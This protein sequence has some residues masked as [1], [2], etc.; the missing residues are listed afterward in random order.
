MALKDS[1]KH[2][3]DFD[4]YSG[5]LSKADMDNNLDLLADEIDVRVK[6]DPDK[7][8]VAVGSGSVVNGT[9]SFAFG[10]NCEANEDN[11]I[12]F[13]YEC[14]ANG[15]NSFAFGYNS[16]TDGTRALAFGYECKATADYSEAW[17]YEC[18]A[19]AFLSYARG[20]Q[21]KASANA[22]QVFG[23]MIEDKQAVSISYGGSDGTISNQ[24]LR[25]F[26]F[27]KTTDDT[28]SEFN[29]PLALWLKSLNYII[30]KC[31]AIKDDYATKWI[32][33]R[34][35]IVRVN[36][37][38]EITIDSDNNT[39]IVKDDSDWAFDIEAVNDSTN[40]TLKLKATG[41]AD[42]NIAWGI[43]VENRQT[44]WN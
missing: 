11:N 36:E 16:E 39:D 38:G 5:S 1:L 32:F 4:G 7:E 27:L 21:V 34:R 14:K 33:E 24:N 20:Y 30:I 42:T 2:F 3:K 44:Y 10:K 25:H 13:G 15:Y 31:E 12:A 22:A 6:F 28:Q 29:T 23:A 17:G 8:S 19:S 43:E 9:R 18:E 35:L 26:N 37:N 41:K 40:P